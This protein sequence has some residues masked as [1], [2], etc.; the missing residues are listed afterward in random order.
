MLNETG[1]FHDDNYCVSSHVGSR[2][3]EVIKVN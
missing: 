2:G 1:E 3:R